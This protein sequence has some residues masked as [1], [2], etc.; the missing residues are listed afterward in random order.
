LSL[1]NNERE[2]FEELLRLNLQGCSLTVEQA[3]R[4][5][6]HYQLLARWNRVVNLSSIRDMATA[7]VRHY[8]ESLFLA[9]HLPR[10]AVSVVDVGSGA[11]F[12]GIP[13]AI[14]RPDCKLA[15]VESHQRKAV[16]LKEATRGFANVSV[17]AGR[18][19]QVKGEFDWLVSRAVAWAELLLLVPRLA[20]RVALLVGVGDALKL[21]KEKQLEWNDPVPLPWGQ[22]RSLVIGRSVS[23]G[24]C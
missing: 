3:G 23:R 16:F 18:A 14:V 1:A 9:A 7:V 8:C 24:T 15:L 19:E 10:E 21:L 13:L 12:P 2:Q 20:S 6:A 4:L 11:G 17:I 22:Q 5:Y